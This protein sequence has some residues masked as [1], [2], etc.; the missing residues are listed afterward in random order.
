[1]IHSWRQL[2]PFFITAAALVAGLFAILKTLSG[3]YVIACQFIMLSMILDGLDGNVARWLNG[4]SDLGAELDTFVDI[5]SFG[6]APAVLAYETTLKHWGFWGLALTAFIV[7]SGAYRLARFK[8]VDPDHGQLGYLGLPI[9]VC[10]G[11]ITLFVFITHAE[12]L[13]SDWFTLAQGPLAI[14]V[15]GATVAMLVLQISH[16]HYGKP[17]KRLFFFV[18]CMFMVLL[19]FLKDK[20]AVSAALAMCAYG[21]FYAFVTPFLPHHVIA[22]PGDE[23]DEEEEETSPANKF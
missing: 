1:M 23:E 17:T 20:M 19:L 10:A 2:I 5:T 14:F 13:D 11:W 16:A 22:L 8:V 7:L 18:L 6:V 12:I 9:T 3:D 15:W 4:C 21:F